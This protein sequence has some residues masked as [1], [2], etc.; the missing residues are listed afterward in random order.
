MCKKSREVCTK[1]HFKD[2]KG[3][4]KYKKMRPIHH[5]NPNNFI[6]NLLAGLTGYICKLNKI[7]VLIS[8]LLEKVNRLLM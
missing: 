5:R 3:E 2:Y 1:G 7:T 8:K 4:E 6:I